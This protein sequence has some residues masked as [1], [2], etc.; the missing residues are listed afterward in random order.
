[1]C[2]SAVWISA[3]PF[4]R[5]R[6]GRPLH[7][8]DVRIRAAAGE[9][10]HQL[11]AARLERG[12]CKQDDRVALL[13]A[14]ALVGLA[15]L[16]LDHA[17]GDARRER[18]RVEHLLDEVGEL[19]SVVRACLRFELAP[20][21]DDVPG[22]A[23][24]DRA[25]VRCRLVVEPSE[26]QVGN[27][28]RSGGDCRAALLRDHPGVRGPAVEAHRQRAPVGRAHDHLA[29]R[30]RLVVDEAELGLEL[31]VVEGARAEKADLLLLREQQLDAGMRPAFGDDPPRR[32]DHRDDGRLVVRAEDRSRGVPDDAVRDDRLER[33]LRR[34]GVEM[35]TEED[36][37]TAVQ[38]SRQPAQ[39]V[40]RVGVDPGPGVVLL[41]LEAQ[42]AQLGGDAIGDRALVSR[43]TGDRAELREEIEGGGHVALDPRPSRS[44]R[45]P[46]VTY[47]YFFY[48]VVAV[49][50]AVTHE[51][52]QKSLVGEAL[53]HGPVA[54]F[55]AGDDGRY[56]AVN[57]YA[58][59][60]LGYTRSELLDLR[61]PDVAVDPDAQI[62][63]AEMRRTGSRTGT[64]QLRRSDGT[65]VEMRF[66]ASQSTVGGMLVYIGIC[67]PAE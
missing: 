10:R 5:L 29:D 65:E 41:D 1:M 22:A 49:A 51:L 11:V 25:D 46:P 40:A 52:V 34:H 32:L 2:S 9:R 31:R 61:V 38:P 56:L 50:S 67:W 44:A 17:L 42:R 18:E 30:R 54:V 12:G 26:P 4:A 27:G 39:Q 28:A 48:Y 19:A 58:C 33:A 63:Y 57:A 6:Q 16:G 64:T 20:L 37:R 62:N 23:A 36:R 14:V 66:R 45:K 60:L 8:E 13:E 24:G 7:V 3:I 15:D 35:R 53:E 47:V 55:V 21:R 43:W 59:E